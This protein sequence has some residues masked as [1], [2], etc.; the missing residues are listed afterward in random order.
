MTC[1]NPLY[2]PKLGM[3]VPCGHCELCAQRRSREWSNRLLLEAEYHSSAIFI[4]LTYSNANLPDNFSL[5]KVDCQLFM[6]RLRKNIWSDGSDQKIKYYLCGEYGPK[7]Q[8]P[9]YHA[10][11]FG[12]RNCEETKDLIERSWNLGHVAVDSFNADAG[13]YVAGYVQKKLYGQTGKKVY[14]RRLPP[15]SLQSQKLGYQYV[16]DNAK[17]LKKKLTFS[18]HGRISSLPRYMRK[19]LEITREQAYEVAKPYIEADFFSAMLSGINVHYQFPENANSAQLVHLR[20]LAIQNGY[21]HG[22][23]LVSLEFLQFL[24]E[25]RKQALYEAKSK[26]KNW[27]EKLCNNEIKQ[28]MLAITV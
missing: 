10:I 6:K 3:Y 12:L 5:S 8:R 23:T 27:R 20:N 7:T 13:Y 14:G 16:I 11:I 25:K 26:L 4:T 24:N 2:M 19:I 21:I 22:D 15:F 9:H 18:L 17:E 28:N 1:A